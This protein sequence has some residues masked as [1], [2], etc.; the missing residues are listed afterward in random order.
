[1]ANKRVKINVG[2]KYGFLTIVKE[3]E[4]KYDKRNKIVRIFTCACD[5]GRYTDVRL[6]SLRQGNTKSCGCYSI[7][8]QKE[9]AIKRN[10]THNLSKTSI[11]KT[12]RSMKHRCFN[13]NN[14]YY[15]HYGGRGITVCER[16]LESFINFYNDMGPKPTPLHSIDR[17]D[18]NGNYDPSNCKWSTSSEQQKNKRKYETHNK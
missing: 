13:S 17:I 3:I 4:P 5:C 8:V 11:Y 16:W 2:D 14:K 6:Y 1:M 15:K 9:N 10:T 12:W 7:D 18:V